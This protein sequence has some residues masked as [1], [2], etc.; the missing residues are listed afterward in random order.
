MVGGTVSEK[1][2]ASL[3]PKQGVAFTYASSTIMKKQWDEHTYG[4]YKAASQ[5]YK[6]FLEW[7]VIE[8]VVEEGH[9][10]AFESRSMLEYPLWRWFF[11]DF[12]KNGL[13]Q[14]LFLNTS[15]TDSGAAMASSDLEIKE[16]IMHLMEIYTDVFGP[17]FKAL[18]FTP[19]VSSQIEEKQASG[20]TQLVKKAMPFYLAYMLELPAAIEEI[21]RRMDEMLPHSLSLFK[22][23]LTLMIRRG[24]HRKEEI[25]EC[26]FLNMLFY[27]S[28]L[29]MLQ[30]RIISC[31]ILQ[32]MA[33]CID[34][35][36]IVNKYVDTSSHFHSF[37]IQALGTYYQ[38]CLICQ[39][40]LMKKLDWQ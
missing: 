25:V 32:I 33:D 40:T 3:K 27:F 6:T 2:P 4:D 38:P 37:L 12:L 11:E 29:P 15:S 10:K 20:A 39:R 31:Q 19:L 16:S 24:V 23:T 14:L 30:K 21:K 34:S 8:K 22:S 26:I 9:P 18:Y 28:T 7:S 5:L 1:F 13:L 17:T 35:P 36:T